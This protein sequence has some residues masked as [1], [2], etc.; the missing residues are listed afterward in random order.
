[1]NAPVEVFLGIPCWS[2]NPVILLNLKRFKHQNTPG[3]GRQE[4]GC[5]RLTPEFR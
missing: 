3:C 1:M 5:I 2:V 4:D